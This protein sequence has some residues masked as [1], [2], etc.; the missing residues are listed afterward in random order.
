MHLAGKVVNLGNKL[1]YVF[2]EKVVDSK[3]EVRRQAKASWR[4][5]K[6]ILNYLLE[7]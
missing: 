4:Y 6:H 3:W 2:K 1:G 7:M 5:L